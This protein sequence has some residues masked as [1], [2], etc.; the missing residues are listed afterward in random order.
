MFPTINDIPAKTKAIIFDLDGTLYNKKHLSLRMILHAPCDIRKMYI[1][2]KTRAS[3]KGR[4]LDDG[5]TFYTQYF[6]AMSAKAGDD[7][8]TWQAWYENQYMPLMVKIIKQHH[9]LGCWV[10]PFIKQCQQKGLRLVVLSDYGY[11]CEKLH[12]LGLSHDMF[13][14]VVS[15]PDLGGLKPARELMK[16]ITEKI[17]VAPQECLIIGDRDDTDGQLASITEANFIKIEY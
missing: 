1:E 16:R 9:P 13:D 3:M 4:W 17:Q 15:A 8:T 7:T 5:A 14:W 10:M 11:T 2:R 6:Q 12:A